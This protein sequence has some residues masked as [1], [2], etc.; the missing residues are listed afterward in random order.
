MN[1]SRILLCCVLGGTASL[2]GCLEPPLDYTELKRVD[3]KVTDAELSSLLRIAQ[4]MPDGRLPRFMHVLEDLPEWNPS[5]NLPVAELVNEQQRLLDGRWSVDRMTEA[6]ASHRALQRALRRE[7][8]TVKQFV[9]L[10]LTVGVA[11]SRSALRENQDL[12]A[13]LQ[14][15]QVA[16]NRLRRD[17]RPYSSLRKSGMYYVSQ[18]SHWI[19]RVQR[20]RYLRIVPPYNIQ[21]VNAHRS[22]LEAAF[23]PQFLLNPLDPVGNP[24]EEWGIPFGELSDSGNDAEIRWDRSTAIIGTAVPDSQVAGDSNRKTSSPDPKTWNDSDQADGAGRPGA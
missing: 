16:I 17:E 21:L 2:A 23:P 15:G 24:A 12:N 10:M 19:T 11:L 9:S 22:D 7:R 5:R 4:S 3:E 20:T 14:N 1:R 8:L 18:Q 13:I 6:L